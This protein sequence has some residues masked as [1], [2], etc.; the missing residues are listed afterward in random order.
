[1]NTSSTNSRGHRAATIAAI[2]VVA[3]AVGGVALL[4]ASFRGD[5][6][7]PGGRPAA[8]PAPR[9]HVSEPRGLAKGKA[10]ADDAAAE[11]TTA[12]EATSAHDQ[13]GAVEAFVSYATWAIASPAAAADPFHASAAL[14]GRLNSADAAMIDAIDRT[15]PHDFVPSAGAY[16]VVGHSGSEATP[17]QVMVEVVAPMT[18]GD[19][20]R[21]S[22]IGGVVAWQGD[23][24]LPTSMQPREVPQP[25]DPTVAL[26][27]L[28]EKERAGLLDGLGWQVFSNAADHG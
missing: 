2:V 24:W 16:R 5:Q 25:A 14:G 28:S 9:G 22:K 7:P 12:I 19:R 17:D 20:I 21:W 4:A 26:A 27:D 23:R 11:A 18:V 8:A 3:L 13:A 15:T 1:M 10:V 6:D